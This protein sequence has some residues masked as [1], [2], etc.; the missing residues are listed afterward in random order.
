MQ[1]PQQQNAL[2]L[3]GHLHNHDENLY[4]NLGDVFEPIP[5]PAIKD[6]VPQNTRLIT[7]TPINNELLGNATL[8]NYVPNMTI[9]QVQ[10]S[11]N[12]ILPHHGKRVAGNRRLSQ[13]VAAMRA[14]KEYL[15]IAE[16]DIPSRILNDQRFCQGKG[17][18][19]PKLHQKRFKNSMVGKMLWDAWWGPNGT[20]RYKC[21]NSFNHYPVHRNFFR[22]LAEWFVLY[23]NPHGDLN[24]DAILGTNPEE[25]YNSYKRK[26][27]KY[28]I[29]DPA[30]VENY[31]DLER[32]LNDLEHTKLVCRGLPLPFALFIDRNYNR[33]WEECLVTAVHMMYVPA[34]KKTH[35]YWLANRQGALFQRHAGINIPTIAI[36]VVIPAPPAV[37]EGSLAEQIIALRTERDALEISRNRSIQRSQRDNNSRR[38]AEKKCAEAKQEAKKANAFLK[39]ARDSRNKYKK[40]MEEARQQRDAFE[41]QLLSITAER[42][43]LIT[44]RDARVSERDTATQGREALQQQLADAIRQRDEADRNRQRLLQDNNRLRGQITELQTQ[45]D[46]LRARTNNVTQGSDAEE[47]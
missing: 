31:D 21:I 26:A 37:R 5:P 22:P 14:V 1:A 24:V 11:L 27:R 10:Q 39:L 32:F 16:F 28:G 33:F 40:G 3:Q 44:E 29:W 18:A 6:G 4:T 12:G 46:D 20:A 9:G 30:V 43:T 23:M 34:E 38:A 8:A 42:N 15:R 36:P 35:Q 47:G 41:Q 45:N 7:I 2:M 17:S 13:S 19:N 25:A